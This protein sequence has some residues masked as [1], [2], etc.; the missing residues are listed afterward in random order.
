MSRRLSYTEHL[1]KTD[2][3]QNVKDRL[4]EEYKNKLDNILQYYDINGIAEYKSDILLSKSSHLKSQDNHNPSLLTPRDILNEYVTSLFRIK[5]D[6]VLKQIISNTYAA[7]IARL[8]TAP[9]GSSILT[10][11]KRGENTEE[12]TENLP[13]Y[14]RLYLTAKRR[15][16]RAH[17]G[18]SKSSHHKGGRKTRRRRQRKHK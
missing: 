2:T 18:T 4:N 17:E 15:T 3:L 6:E 11:R 16:G 12:T 7:K 14:G 9:H 10:K 1:T 8:I 13:P 5:N